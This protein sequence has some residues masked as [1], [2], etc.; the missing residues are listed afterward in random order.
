MIYAQI[1]GY[2]CFFESCSFSGTDDDGTESKSRSD[3][4]E[5]V[6]TKDVE[7]FKKW[8]KKFRKGLS[9]I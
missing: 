7:M 6:L 4:P 8:R 9:P 5:E 3:G 2:R 1:V